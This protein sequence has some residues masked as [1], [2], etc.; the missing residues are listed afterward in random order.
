MK[1]MAPKKQRMI[2]GAYRYIEYNGPATARQMCDALNEN[3]KYVGISYITNQ[4]SMVLRFSNL[5]YKAGTEQILNNGSYYDMVVWD[6]VPLDIVARGY[7]KEVKHRLIPIKNQPKFV[8]E[9]IR[10]YVGG[11]E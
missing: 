11:A 5:F 8:Q 1:K 4:L 9:Y 2:G 10:E 3:T 6:I 7:A